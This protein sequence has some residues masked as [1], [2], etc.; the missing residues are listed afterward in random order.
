[1]GGGTAWK[2]IRHRAK[3]LLLPYL[4][5]TMVYMTIYAVFLNKELSLKY[6]VSC[7]LLGKTATP[8]YYIIVLT[9]FTFLTPWLA[10]IVSDKRFTIAIVSVAVGFMVCGYV[11]QFLGIQAFSLMKYSPIWIGFYYFGMRC[12][13]LSILDRIKGKNFCVILVITYIIELLETL[14]LIRLNMESIAYSQMRITSF[15]YAMAFLMWFLQKRIGDILCNALAFVGDNS[16][17]VFFIHYLIILIIRPLINNKL[18]YP[19]GM[20]AEFI[21]ALFF[22]LLIIKVVKLTD[23]KTLH[24][25][26]GI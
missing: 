6:I 14:I 16:Y 17:G 15:L 26:T 10:S 4:F 1:M 19:V 11:C 7:L 3:R 24:I 9:Y 22:S 23:S 12:R 21:S 5:W 8:F 18:L 25:M 20:T 2:W 13:K